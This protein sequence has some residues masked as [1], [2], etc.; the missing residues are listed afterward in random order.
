MAPQ[1]Y[2]ELLDL[3]VS[4]VSPDVT[5]LRVAQVT[6]A[7][8]VPPAAHQDHQEPQDPQVTQAGMEGQD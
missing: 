3:L 4:Q 7:Q 8:L 5:E 1:V 6:R 2:V